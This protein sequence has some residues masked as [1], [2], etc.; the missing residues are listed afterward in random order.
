M[1]FGS[2][3]RLKINNQTLLFWQ[4]NFRTRIH[5]KCYPKAMI[6]KPYD[7][8]LTDQEKVSTTQSYMFIPP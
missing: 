6:R 1:L 7:T 3:T 2:A 5:K 4:G 8:D